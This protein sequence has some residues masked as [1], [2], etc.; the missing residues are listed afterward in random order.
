ME[1]QVLPKIQVKI[2][3]YINKEYQKSDDLAALQI[4]LMDDKSSRVIDAFCLHQNLDIKYLCI[5]YLTSA[6]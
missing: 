4:D 3:T 5:F 2:D 1:D 6:P